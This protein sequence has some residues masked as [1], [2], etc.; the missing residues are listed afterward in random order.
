LMSLRLVRLAK[1]PAPAAILTV[2]A[3][4]SAVQKEPSYMEGHMILLI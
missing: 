3:G 1:S 4:I 2:L